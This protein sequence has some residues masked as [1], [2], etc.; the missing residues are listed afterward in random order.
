MPDSLLNRQQL[1]VC[2]LSQQSVLQL[3]QASQCS[4]LFSVLEQDPEHTCRQVIEQACGLQ[5]LQQHIVSLLLV[6]QLLGRGTATFASPEFGKGVDK[7]A[8]RFWKRSGILSHC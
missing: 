4:N 1:S 2:P 8:T 5:N 7:S 3:P 6:A